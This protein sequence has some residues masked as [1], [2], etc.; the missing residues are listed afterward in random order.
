MKPILPPTVI[1]VAND[2]K[3]RVTILE[4]N[5]RPSLA[6]TASKVTV[7]AAGRP[8]TFI[9]LDESVSFTSSGLRPHTD[10]TIQ[11]IFVDVEQPTDSFEFNIRIGE[12]TVT[13]VVMP[14]NTNH[15]KVK[16][17]P[18]IL[19]PATGTLTIQSSSVKAEAGFVTIQLIGTSSTIVNQTMLL[20]FNEAA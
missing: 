8:S 1:S 6:R 4:R 16:V 17:S 18:T 10:L 20:R 11:E 14:S 12:Q 5:T 7:S 15:I 13:T 9:G 3:D 19:L 2:V